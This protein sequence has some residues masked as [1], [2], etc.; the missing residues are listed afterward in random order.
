MRSCTMYVRR[1]WRGFDYKTF[2]DIKRNASALVPHLEVQLQL[3]RRRRGGI[4]CD[5]IGLR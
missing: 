4:F 2:A 1:R 3:K 5:A